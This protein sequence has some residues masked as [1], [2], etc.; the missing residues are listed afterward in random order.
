VTTKLERIWQYVE[1]T[2]IAGE[3]PFLSL[4]SLSQIDPIPSS[5]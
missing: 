3:I 2:A 4:Q 1:I 5:Q